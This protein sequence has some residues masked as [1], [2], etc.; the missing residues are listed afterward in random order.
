MKDEVPLTPEE[1][2]EEALPALDGP[3]FQHCGAEFKK[4]LT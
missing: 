1:I 3:D 2:I 4:D